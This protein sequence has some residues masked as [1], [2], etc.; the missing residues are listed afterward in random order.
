METEARSKMKQSILSLPGIGEKRAALYARLGIETVEDLLRHFPRAYQNRSE[1]KP[2]S[3]LTDGE[4]AAVIVTVATDARVTPML[5]N[6]LQLV[7]L[8]VF[9]DTASA[10]VTFFGQTYLKDVFKTGMCFRLWGKF[11]VRMRAIEVTS[12]QFEPVSPLHPLPDFIPVYP[13]T[14]GLSQKMLSHAIGLALQ[15]LPVALPDPIPEAVRLQYRLLPLSDAYRMIHRPNSAE[16]IEKAKNRFVFE[17]LYLFSLGVS[18]M[19]QSRTLSHAPAL[20]PAPIEPFLAALPFA[21]T[22]DQMHCVEDIR[23]DLAAPVPMARLVSGDV[24]SGKTAVAAAAIYLCVKGGY[25]AMLMAPTEILA[26][27]HYQELSSLFASLGIECALLTG[28]T[29]VAQKRSIRAALAAGTLPL[30][31]G[32]HALLSEGVSPAKLGLVVTDEQHRFGVNQRARLASEGGTDPH[33]LVMSATPIPRTLALILFGDLDASTIE[34]LPP[35]RQ[36][37]DTFVVDEAYRARLNNFIRKQVEG[38]GQVYVVC[39]AIEPQEEEEPYAIGKFLTLAGKEETVGEEEDRLHYA[40]LH[41]EQMKKWFPEIEIACLHGR[42]K[43]A[44]K[45]RVMQDF[46]SGKTKI[47]VSTTV[48]EVGVNVPTATLMLIENAERFGL[49]QLHQL[50]GRVG[51]GRMKS[52]CVLVSDAKG[53]AAKERLSVLRQCANG[54]QI[55]KEDLRLRGP[56]DFFPTSDGNARQSGE[57]ALGA[58]VLC[59]DMAQ[60][61]DAASAAAA[62]VAADPHRTLPE[63]KHAWEA[64]DGIFALHHRSMN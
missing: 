27:Q 62:T 1:I 48:I 15:N 35:G 58:A 42:M 2:L 45:E 7:K 6:R 32:T 51:R 17:A 37:V 53:E 39:P 38:G 60:L 44:E 30:V 57:F 34:T 25:Q 36:K 24:G 26:R 18:A 4:T 5:K 21:L 41:A 63:Y 33:V 22:P 19:K 10:T 52:Y 14:E 9:D 3:S 20:T 47:L 23:R 54:Y 29:K 56:G 55:A 31:I 64:V 40:T 50:R 49:S 28:S 43:P 12:P 13:L 46:V 11:S 16:E 8:R 59:N 61:N